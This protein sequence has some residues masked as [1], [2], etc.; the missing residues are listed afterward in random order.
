VAGVALLLLAVAASAGRA[1]ARDLRSGPVEDA[2]DPV[3]LVAAPTLRDADFART[4]VAVSFPPD[5]GPMGVILNRPAGASLGQVLGP[6]RPDLAARDDPLWLGGPVAQDGVVFVFRAPEHPLVA[7]PLGD[8]CWL[9]G[10]GTLFAAAIARS[11]AATP[12]FFL[13]FAQWA[14]GQLDAEIARGDWWVLPMDSRV[15]FDTA[16]PDLWQALVDRV[17]SPSAQADPAARGASGPAAVAAL[18][19]RAA[20]P[21]PASGG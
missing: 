1:V 11:D 7:L 21:S 4:V 12:R 10:D 14:D 18:R 15:L 2:R 19:R 16:A 8:D 3:L 5:V 9:S 20:S 17:R 13:G 6:S